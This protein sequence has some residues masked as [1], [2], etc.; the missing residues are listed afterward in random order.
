MVIGCFLFPQPARAKKSEYAEPIKRHKINI[1]KLRQEIRI[2]LD[3]IKQSGEQEV[4]LLGELKQVDTKLSAQKKKLNTLQQRLQAQETL[5]ALKKLDREQ[6][7]LVRENVRVH[8]KKRLRSFYLMG[9]TGVLNVTFSN[10]SLPDLMLFNDSFQQL[11]DYDQSVIEIYHDTIEQLQ[12]A[13]EAQKLEKTLL[14]TF[15]KQAEK[16]RQIMD[17]IRT[18]KQ[19]L[20]SRV[21]SKKGLYEQAIRE[22]QRAEMALTETLTHLKQKEENRVR[23]FILNKGKMAAPVTGNLSVEFG[24]PLEGGPCYGI[25]IETGDQEPVYSIYNGKVLFAGYKNGYGNLVIIDHGLQYYTITSRLDEILVQ[26][27]SKIR[28][29]EQ[30]GI[31]GDIATLF[32][33][34]LYFEIRHGSEPLDPLEWL[35]DNS[36]PK[37]KPLPL[38]VLPDNQ[39]EFTQIRN[40]TIQPQEGIMD[41]NIDLETEI[42]IETEKNS[43]VQ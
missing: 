25:T 30:I 13:R 17:E 35:Q 22:M 5:L 23:G 2:H 36:Y 31:T 12:R 16:E 29:R 10:K 42:E 8:L 27:G 41:D 28:T 19:Q 39:G 37:L 15:I 24:D 4:S 3:K 9:K 7:E 38:P 40:Y 14:L 21:R 11:L 43:A 1:G 26:E 32:S 20:L 34:G 33:Q 18:E 6:A